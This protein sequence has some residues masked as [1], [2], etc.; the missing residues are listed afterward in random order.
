MSL[1]LMALTFKGVVAVEQRQRW[2]SS[3]GGGGRM[4]MASAL[5]TIC[6]QSY[7]P[8][9]HGIVLQCQTRFLQT[10]NIGV[11]MMLSFGVATALHAALCWALVLKY[12]LG[13]RGAAISNLE[14][15]HDIPSFLKLAIPSAFMVCL[16][17]WSFELMVLLSGRLPN[18]KLQ[19][20]IF[21]ICTRVSNELGAG[22]PWSARLPVHVV[23]VAAII[24]DHPKTVSCYG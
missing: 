6:G 14:A 2:W 15:F 3:Y 5:D 19:T 20:S 1:Y 12:D 24:E 9:Q 11:S 23:V 10:Q 17:L 13:S 8:G 4:G 22:N 18:P 7:G 21:S 16:E